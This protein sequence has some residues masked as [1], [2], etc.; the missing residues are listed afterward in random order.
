MLI[1]S[2]GVKFGDREERD[3]ADIYALPADEALRRTFTD[4][5]GFVPDYPQL[6]DAEL[7]AIAH[8]REATALYG[9]KPYMHNPALLH[10]LHR[11]TLPSLV[12]WGD[13]DGIVAPSYG[14]KLAASLPNA[15]FESIPGA[16]HYPQIEQPEAVADHIVRFAQENRP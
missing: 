15:R 1:D 2:L 10:W 11:I 6:D 8:D 5:A 13:K 7:Q 12:L 14:E 4:P 16:A 3:I 9:W